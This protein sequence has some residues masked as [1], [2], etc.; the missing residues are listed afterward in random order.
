VHTGFTRVA[1]VGEARNMDRTQ[2][3]A[4]PGTQTLETAIHDFLES[5]SKS[6]NYRSNLEY[7][8]EKF[9]SRVEPRGVDTLADIDKQTMAD[10]ASYLRERVEAHQTP[11]VDGG[12]AA[13]TAWAYYDNVSAFFRLLPQVGQ[14]RREPGPESRRQRRAART[15]IDGEWRPTVLVAQRAACAP[16]SRRPASLKG[17]RRPRYRGRRRDPGQSPRLRAGLYGR[18]WG[19]DPERQSGRSARRASVGRRGY[20]GQ[21]DHD[22]RQEPTAR[23][24]PTA[25]PNSPATR[26]T[27]ACGRASQRR[28]AGLR[29]APCAVDVPRTARRV[30]T[31]RRRLAEPAFP[32]SNP[33]GCAASTLYKRRSISSQATLRRW[34]DRGRR[35]PRVSHL[36]RR[37]AWGRRETVSGAWGCG[38]PTD[39]PAR[40]SEDD[41][42]DVF[43]YRDQ[44]ERRERD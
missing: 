1:A 35:R 40:R 18:P 2:T 33:W 15:T 29:L 19:R 9:R 44:R 28:V 11:G 21:P 12:I 38:G 41:L 23:A 32:L 30:R 8:L 7:V 6:G 37:T 13:S 4:S 31:A 34:R 25:R 14:D 16:G 43:A 22:P 36:A 39:T 17:D 26:T 27:Q 3:D 20:R 24:R 42:R 5:G 10:Y